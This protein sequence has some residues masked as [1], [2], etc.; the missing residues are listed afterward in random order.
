MEGYAPAFV[1][2]NVPF[3]VVSGLS[4]SE[5]FGSDA[6]QQCCQI[7]SEIPLINN[8][9]SQA[10]LKLF[11][12]RDGGQLSW[13]SKEYNGR[14]KFKIKVVGREYNLP[15]RMAQLHAPSARLSNSRD[16]SPM[17][18]PTAHSPLSP[19]TPDSALFP[20]GLIDPEWISKHQNLVPSVFVSFYKF[21]S[22]PNLSTLHD[23]HLKTDISNIKSVIAKS[24]YKTKLIVALLSEG[25]ILKSP[26]VED[27]LANIR[28]ATGLDSKTSLFFLPPQSSPVEIEAFVDT[29]ISTI[30]PLCIEYYR[31][32][33]K[34]S[35]RK[36]NRGV[37]PSLSASPRIGTTTQILSSQA[38][39][40]RYDFKLGVFA[41]FRQEMDAAIRS[42]ESGYDILLSEVMEI[43][44]SW[45]PRFI[46]ARLLADVFAIRTLR[47]LLWNGN[48]TGAVRR[49]QSHRNRLRK[50]IDRKGKGTLTY[51][52]EAWEARWAEVMAEMIQKSA[53]D[54]DDESMSPYL[55]PEKNIVTGE[56]LEPWEY[57]HHPGYWYSLASQHQT[58]RRALAFAIPEEDRSPQTGKSPRNQ[59]YDTYLCPDPYEEYPLPGQAGV[60]HSLLIIESLTKA[61]I[62][63]NKRNQLRQVQELSI[64]SATESIRRKDWD[65]ALR[66]L[67]PLWHK[68]SYRKEGWWGP[69]E[70]V[71][72]ALRNAAANAGDA[73]SVISVDWELLH[74]I[75]VYRPK[76]HY[77]I[78]KALDGIE[79]ID[80]RPSVVIQHQ[81]VHSFLLATY[82]FQN[83]EGKVG[84]VCLSQLAVVSTAMP[85]SIPVTMSEIKI[86]FEGSMKPIIL[87]HK[88]SDATNSGKYSHNGV[89][90]TDIPSQT[91][92]PTLAGEADLTFSP[93]QAKV[94][95]FTCLLR[96]ASE[97]TAT[98]A[99]FS[100]T[101]KLFDLDFVQTFEPTAAPATWWT[102]TSAKKQ[103]VREN[104]AA[105]TILPKPPKMEVRFIGLQEQYYTNESL[106]LQIDFVNDEEIDAVATIDVWLLGDNVPPVS[107]SLISPDHMADSTTRSKE[108]KEEVLSAF[109]IGTICSGASSS[110]R[111]SIPPIDVPAFYE[112]SMKVSY[113]LVSDME[114]PIYKTAATQMAI[115][116]PFEANYD[117]SPLIHPDPWPSF[118]THNEGDDTG[119]KVIHRG[120]SQ[121]WCLTSRY[122]SFANEDLVVEDLN[123]D[124]IGTNGGIHCYA[125]KT[126]LPE[127]GVVVSPKSLDEAKFEINS[128]KLSLDDRGTATLDVTL[129]IKWRRQTERSALNTTILAVPR[130]LVSSSEPRVLAS[131]SYSAIEPFMIH[132]EVT[133]ENPSNHFLSFGITM[134]PSEKWAFSGVKASTL[135]LVPLSR[136]SLTFR[137]VPFTRGD[138]IGPVRCVIK[139]R[140]F[141]KILKIAPTDGMRIDKEGIFVWA[142]PAEIE[143]ASVLED[144]T[145]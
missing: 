93:G 21:T 4:P 139:D 125:T 102:S 109:E 8:G 56:R 15:P 122:F 78:S 92:N 43:M 66:I 87:R 65:V 46:E 58:S 115:I 145:E 120:L 39:N 89:T 136:K 53:I 135:Q 133:I 2:H 38:W 126:D 36:R 34:H 101:S 103:L 24:G 75:F 143:E 40:V 94:F 5:N 86:E 127:G 90:L 77:D 28:K 141:Q 71:G 98:S 85:A 18:R 7:T 88:G 73:I 69:V 63:F 111:M 134:E 100:M 27:R 118:F 130:L 9:E 119:N 17:P 113:H 41:E 25:S 32:L 112:L 104:P 81:D 67:R 105:I 12:E 20:D 80:S 116:N 14:N 61:I 31:E 138:W 74:K 97:G 52:W 108:T 123:V 96:E 49:W 35:R 48:F 114:T 42:F 99:T 128:Q 22:D 45:S 142:P 70:E 10:F 95:E 60:D 121:K 44:P 13:N 59:A 79:T 129:A 3:M 54:F 19:L 57:M 72:W 55:L 144:D 33:S 117:F 82:V 37:V 23:N 16:L 76:W 131:V 51:G 84:E 1:A 62:E 140:Y 107:L 64:I 47:C 68:M 50:F 83:S 137:L 132:F 26:E 11:Q 6:G 110:V 91:G 124:V 29:I 106:V 30:Y